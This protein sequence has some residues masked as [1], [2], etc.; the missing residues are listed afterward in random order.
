MHLLRFR[1][2][3]AAV[4]LCFG[5]T[6]A[7]VHGD[8][9]YVD[10]AAASGG[11][12]STWA[13]ALCDLDAALALAEA[14]DQVRVAAGRYVPATVP[15][16]E[17]PR[18]AV[19][20]V[21]PG[22]HV[23][24]GWV[25]DLQ[26]PR[27]FPTVLS[28]DRADDDHLGFRADNCF[29]VVVATGGADNATVLD[30]LHV[31]GGTGGDGSAGGGV[32]VLD[33]AARM[34]RCTLATNTADEGGAIAIVNAWLVIHASTIRDND[35]R[36]GGGVF[37][38]AGSRLDLDASLLETNAALL[39]GGG[40]HVAPGAIVTARGC[41]LEWNTALTGG[42]LAIG[43]PAAPSSATLVNCRLLH[44][45]AAFAGGGLI[46]ASNVDLA[47]TNCLFAANTAGR[48]GGLFVGAG[49]SLVNCTVTAN[50]GAG[51]AWGSLTPTPVRLVNSIAWGNVPVSL[52]RDPPGEY[53][54]QAEFNM[55]T[56]P[57]LTTRT[58]TSPAIA[59]SS[60]PRVSSSRT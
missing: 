7:S 9:L 26:D 20:N 46:A 4:I 52:L 30:G 1:I 43:A 58:S 17:D 44:N 55:P 56:M 39:G 51:L 14:G 12:G 18:A 36:L 19:F 13:T 6:S 28:G 38:A 59:P 8:I 10:A 11:D 54:N 21:A 27:A 53:H 45:T 2:A 60:C 49:A 35:A 50:V 40:V 34:D 16:G 25:G 24:G 5:A 47:A 22:V 48:G 41:R 29:R 15:A 37:V 42:G 32:L 57:R 31:E 3:L 33:G 23:S